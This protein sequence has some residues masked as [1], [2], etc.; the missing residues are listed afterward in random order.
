MPD[1]SQAA[2]E[3]F[4]RHTQNRPPRGWCLFLGAGTS[5]A[6]GLPT[7]TE[8]VETVK[9]QM[10]ATTDA[11]KF[12]HAVEQVLR[13]HH[14]T[15]DPARPVNVEDLLRELIQAEQL[16]DGKPAVELRYAGCPITPEVLRTA[17]SGIKAI[18][19]AEIAKDCQFDALF[20]F[21]RQWVE[22]HQTLDVFTTNW[23]NAVERVC[24]RLNVS[25]EVDLRC[26]DGFKGFDTKVM[27]LA[28]FADAEPHAK[29]P[30]LH[31]VMLYK[32]HGS[33]D[34]RQTTHPTPGRNILAPLAAARGNHTEEVMIYPTPRK[35]REILGAPYLDLLRLFGD[36]LMAPQTKYLLVIGSSFPDEH[37]NGIIAS[38]LRRPDFNLFVVNPA[39]KTSRVKT[40]LGDSPR[41]HE[42]L[43]YRLE[44]FTRVCQLGRT[45]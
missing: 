31:H 8:L 11:G 29:T 15:V 5:K 18:C 10:P 40:M 36:R 17:V 7:M 42:V 1:T 38:A 27:D 22:P 41:I 39:L 35:H 14:A 34:W 33:V 19:K 2:L 43:P 45:Q 3:E 37:I 30:G 4:V 20:G 16:V 44:D 24:D 13:T 25:G 32:L 12:V 21:L 6:D 23:D 28:L 26:C 9:Q